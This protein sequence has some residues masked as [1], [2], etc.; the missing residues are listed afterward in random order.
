MQGHEFY[1]QTMKRY[2][3]LFG[4]LFNDIIISRDNE[5]GERETRFKVPIAYGP[6]QKFIAR[7]KGDP[8]LTRGVAITLPRLAYEVV[9]IAYD[10]NRKKANL[11]KYRKAGQSFQYDPVPYNINFQLSLI[12]KYAEDA[13][14]IIEQILPFFRP[15][16]TASVEL[17]EGVYVDTAITLDGVSPQDDYEGAFDDRRTLIWTLDFT[18]YGC[19]FGPSYE[20]KLIK[21]I[22]IDFNTKMKYENPTPEEFVTIQPGMKEDGTPTTDINETIPWNDINK[23][24]DWDFIVQILN[25]NEYTRQ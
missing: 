1:N 15:D 21:F 23:E 11:S 3:A 19:F 25:A 7:E 2:V 18:L 20:K 12:S 24:D 17:I 16:W 4:T 9:G 14:K 5:N 10:G 13:H 22:D 6:T 8:N